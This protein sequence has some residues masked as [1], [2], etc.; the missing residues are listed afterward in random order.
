MSRPFI[1][2]IFPAFNEAN[3]IESTVSEAV[4]YFQAHGL[5][6]EIIVSA[7]GN[8]GTREKVCEMSFKNPRIRTI[9]SVQRL[10]KGHGI[11]EAVKIA[12]GQIIG[13]SDADNKTV[14]TEFDKFLPLLKQG[15]QV[16][17]G[18]R[19]SESAI[20]ERPQRWY[21]RWGSRGFGIFMHFIIGLQDIKDTQCGFKFFQG[22]IAKDLFERQQIDGYMYDV[23]I[24]YLAE[25]LRYSIQ[26]VPVR[27]RDDGDSRLQLLSGNIKNFS[28]IVRIR[29]GLAK[30][31]PEAAAELD[32]PN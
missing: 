18:T 25:K 6:Y 30:R 22:A 13:F 20:I 5:S 23:E 19:A 4:E 11:R 16:V 27:W 15:A 12:Q 14:I 31:N 7:D 26:Q 32:T 17:I 2:L 9:G 24:L 8:D 21:R 29:F 1:S 10:G 28:D 3:R